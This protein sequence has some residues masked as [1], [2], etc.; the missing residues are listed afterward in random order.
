MYA[1]RVTGSFTSKIIL[2]EQATMRYDWTQ[3]REMA[4]AEFR[5]ILRTLKLSR[6]AC[7]RFLGVSERTARRYAK[8]QAT[9]P[10]ASVLLLR[11]ILASG[12][13]ALYIP[14]RALPGN[15]YENT[16]EHVK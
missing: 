6:A 4:P 2:L 7:A 1:D 3:Q 11:A 14:P 8:G 5:L 15:P 13:C 12:R 16:I 9:I 10:A